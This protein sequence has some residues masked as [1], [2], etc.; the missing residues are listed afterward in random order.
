[1]CN[2]K[3]TEIVLGLVVL[4]FALWETFAYSKWVLVV[5]AVVLILHGLKCSTLASCAPSAKKPASRPAARR[6][7]SRK[8]R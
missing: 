6:K 5:A 3:A 4:V 2:C 1:M 8:K 7:T